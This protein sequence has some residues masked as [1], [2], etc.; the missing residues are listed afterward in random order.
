MS[1]QPSD[2]ESDVQVL[3]EE[4]G[5]PA[6]VFDDDDDVSTYV[7][8]CQIWILY[9]PRHEMAAAYSVTPFRHSFCHHSVSVHY[10]RLKRTYS[11]QI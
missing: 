8:I 10:L 9:F 7:C 1:R 4:A 5:L 3:H 2:E 11:I 6:G